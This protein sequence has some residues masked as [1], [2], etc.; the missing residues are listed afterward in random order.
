MTA[1][2]TYQ[3]GGQPISGSLTGAETVVVGNGGPQITTATTQQI[4]N[5]AGENAQTVN[6]AIA[7]AIGGTLTA[8]AIVG[9][10]ITRSGPTAVFSDATDSA[11]AIIAAL[12]NAFVGQSFYVRILN[13][14]AFAQTITQGSGVTLTGIS[15]IPAKMTGE[16]LVTYSAAGAVTMYGVVLASS[17]GTITDAIQNGNAQCTS[18]LTAQTNTTLANITGL[19]VTVTAAG[20][21][22]VRAHLNGTAGASG[23]LK[24]AFSGTATATSSNTTAWNWNGTTLNAVTNQTAWGSAATAATAAYTDLVIEGSIVV[25]AAGTIT[26]AA[27]QNASNGTATTVLPGSTLSVERVS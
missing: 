26:L 2:K 8:A 12:T 20:V 11:A 5:L 3:A 17:A 7:T 13:T 18:T 25:L 4:A 15:V 14:T 22:N 9:R 10:L 23:G 24:V 27:A 6:T 21:Y 19:S 16:F 1:P